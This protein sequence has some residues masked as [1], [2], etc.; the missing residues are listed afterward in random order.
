MTEKFK[1]IELTRITPNPWNPRRRFEGQKF[2]DLVAS[3]RSKGVLEPIL[4][5]PFADGPVLVEKPGRCPNH[6][7]MVDFEVIAGERRFRACCRIARDNG[8]KM[9]KIPAIIKDLDDDEAFDVMTIENIQREDLTELE[10]ARN[11]QLYLERKGP[12]AA[13][14]LSARTGIHPAYIRRR[15]RVLALPAEVLELWEQGRL[16][17]GHLEQLCRLKD[18]AEIM[19]HCREALGEGRASWRG[20]MTV[21]E[22]K[23]NID[24][25]SPALSDALFDLGEEGCLGCAHNSDVQ[26]K[27]FDIDMQDQAHCD[28][29]KCFKQKQNNWLMANWENSS[30]RKKCRTN[31]FRFDD[32]FRYNDH[33]LFHRVKDLFSACRKCEHL[34][35]IIRPSGKVFHER[36]CI[37][38]A[39]Y[40]AREKEARNKQ[41]KPAPDCDAGDVKEKEAPRVAWHGSHFREIFYQ[42]KIRERTERMPWNDDRML[43]MLLF[44]LLCHAGSTLG[45]WFGRRHALAGPDGEIA[46]DSTYYWLDRNAA[47]ERIMSMDINAV[48]EDLGDATVE[49][50][51]DK[52]QV[53]GDQRRAIGGLLGIDLSAEWRIDAEY[54]AKKTTRE[55]LSFGQGLGIFDDPAAVSFL[56]NTLGRKSFRACKKAE[57]VRVI[58]ESGADL[59]G[60]VPA[61]IL[62]S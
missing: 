26:K 29:P 20:P 54:L 58:L 18:T 46:E 60:K 41:Q 25:D 13:V 32:F 14:D 36:C 40:K 19:E 21:R 23:D 59:A 49:L 51:L 34:V 42:Q 48:W 3:I 53:T 43:R 6:G 62:N 11:F 35:T 27:L 17:Y 30:I 2:E 37:D 7:K 50:V 16:K 45:T 57:L 1:H 56:Q 55:I 33:P 8:T 31:G 47:L 4:V 5:R 24:E 28:D 15:V 22:L 39:C 38:G 52:A 61:E 9:H 44:A 10:E 12:E